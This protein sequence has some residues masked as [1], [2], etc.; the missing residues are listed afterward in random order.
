[1]FGSEQV[2]LLEGEERY[3]D[4]TNVGNREGFLIALPTDK[5]NALLLA[6]ASSVII[7]Q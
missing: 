4:Y 7:D 1:M 3:K 2:E 6:K 5:R